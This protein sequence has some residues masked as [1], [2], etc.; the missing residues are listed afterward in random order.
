MCQLSSVADLVIEGLE[1]AR[2]N[3]DVITPNI[4][5]VHVKIIIAKN[6]NDFQLLN[7]LSTTFRYT[8]ISSI[9]LLKHKKYVYEV[10]QV[11][12][13][14]IHRKPVLLNIT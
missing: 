10:N 2:L 7:K 1:S 14:A 4:F 12:L 8:D 5:H 6:S 13:T 3:H 9:Y 11:G